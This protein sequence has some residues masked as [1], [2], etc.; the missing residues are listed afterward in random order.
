MATF[1]FILVGGGTAGCVLAARLSEDPSTRVLLLEAGAAEPSAGMADPLA[2]PRLAGTSVDWNYATVPQR[3]TDNAVIS[4][5]RGKVL[6]GSSGINGMM[7][8]RG[9]RAGYDAWAATGASDWNYNT[10][11]PFLKRSEAS[12]AGDPAYRGKDGPMRVGPGPAGDPLWEA[13]F[14]A[15]TEAGHSRNDDGNG[16]GKTAE[17][18]SWNDM[19][20]VDGR[21]QS[22]ADA[23]L[24][25]TAGRPNLTVVTKAHARRLIL[26][27]GICHGVEYRVGGETR[28]AFAD[29]EVI[30]TA[31][32]IGSPELLML[33]GIGPARHLRDLGIDVRADLPGVGGNLQDHPKSQIAY[34]A[35][36]TVRTG[37]YARK[38]HVLLRGDPAAAP[39]LQ[40]IFIDLPVHPRWVPG[41]EDGYSVIF[42]LMTPASRGTVRLA[43]ADPTRAPL[44]DPNYLAN[45]ADVSR[46]IAG[47]R[48]AREV[49][50][51]HALADLRDQELFPGPDVE[52]GASDTAAHAY[53]RRTVTSYFH[54]VGTCAL[55]RG[56]L[57]VVDPELRVR[58]IECLRVADASVMP[59][60]VSGN[61]NAAVLAIA[62]RAAALVTGEETV[63]A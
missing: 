16:N 26:D 21:R 4:W 50:G 28:T 62:E 57:A 11:L 17:G 13:C 8:I 48:A 63:P 49:G 38:P 7:H 3:G 53:L 19:N 23:Y 25:A 20:V 56:Q 9:D 29:R 41:P 39:D 2:W 61:T 60:L 27:G 36:R 52:P 43:S 15:A 12:E 34:T 35:T 5:P 45:P 30:L 10:M 22:S 54:P 14:E 33:S 42:S 47:L 24:G 55:G 32:A 59:T 1:E 18:T 37:R 51:A 46:M 44:I 6:G 58:G 31:G 40:M